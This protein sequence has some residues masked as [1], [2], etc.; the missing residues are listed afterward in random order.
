MYYRLEI[1]K[2]CGP[3]PL[4]DDTVSDMIMGHKTR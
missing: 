4:T 3:A 1:A 2:N